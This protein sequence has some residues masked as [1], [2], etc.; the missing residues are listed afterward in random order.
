[1]ASNSATK[2]AS[3]QSIKAYVDTQITAEDLDIITDSGTID[4]DLDSESLRLV[5]GTGIDTSASGTQVT[6]AVDSTI[7]TE[8]FAT[9]IAVALG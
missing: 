4:I 6:V 3:Q 7:A 1:M 9:A 2:L 8:S 5:G